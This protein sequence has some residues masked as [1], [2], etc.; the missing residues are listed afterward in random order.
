MKI[1]GELAGLAIWALSIA[2]FVA[3]VAA[4]DNKL[5]RVFFHSECFTYWLLPRP[6]AISSYSN[7]PQRLRT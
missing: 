1:M 7:Q 6:P 3:Y 4:E 2:V 5:G